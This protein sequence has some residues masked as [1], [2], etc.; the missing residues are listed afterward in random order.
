MIHILG[1]LLFLVSARAS[2]WKTFHLVSECRIYD[3]KD[4]LILEYPGAMCKFLSDGSFINVTTRGISLIDKNFHVIWHI[5]GHFH[6]QIALSENGQKILALSSEIV[7]RDNIKQ[8]VDKV[9]TIDLK[10]NVIHQVLSDDLL[11][12]AKIEKKPLAIGPVLFERFKVEV[13]LTHFN[14]FYEIPKLNTKHVPDYIKQGNF[15]LNGRHDGI[16]IVSAD[17]KTLLHHFNLSQSINH[18]VHDVQVMEDGNYL[19]F[20]NTMKTSQPMLLFSAIQEIDS[21]TKKVVYE[22][23]GNPKGIFHSYVSGAVQKLD[24]NHYLLTHPN[25]GSFLLSKS[26]DRFLNVYRSTHWVNRMNVPTHQV[27]AYDLA[28]FLKNK[29]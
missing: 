20:N 29:K 14:S 4:R 24:Q 21:N 2:S 7:S 3:L 27:R 1:I 28:D 16:F 12:Q 25:I 9:M 26:E 6:H 22:F 10:G 13:E 11:K 19:L 8:R 5:E 15:I 23:S 18:A 17:L